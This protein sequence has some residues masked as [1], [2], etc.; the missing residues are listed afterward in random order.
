MRTFSARTARK[1]DKNG[2]DIS[3]RQAQIFALTFNC[4]LSFHD[5]IQSTAPLTKSTGATHYLDQANC[6]RLIWGH[7]DDIRNL[8]QIL[9]YT[10]GH[11]EGVNWP[12]AARR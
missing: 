8:L 7:K 6:M 3:D 12:H 9:N 4:D 1:I 10:P 2:I 11:Y 5:T